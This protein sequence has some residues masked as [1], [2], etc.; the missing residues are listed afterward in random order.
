MTNDD[1]NPQNGMIKPPMP[2]GSNSSNFMNM[3]T[4]NVANNI[5]NVSPNK[6]TRK[7]VSYVQSPNS[8]KAGG[9]IN[10]ADTF[11]KSSTQKA[12]FQHALGSNPSLR[13]KK[14]Q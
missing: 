12:N 6:P 2:T 3:N 5:P 9:T 14:A 1:Y 11:N 7:N 8:K 10:I 4:L 13:N